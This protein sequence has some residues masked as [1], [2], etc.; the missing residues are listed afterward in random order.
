VVVPAIGVHADHLDGKY[1]LD[2][3]AGLPQPV[4]EAGI[5]IAGAVIRCD[6]LQVGCLQFLQR[7]QCGLCGA[8]KRYRV[9]EQVGQYRRITGIDDVLIKTEPAEP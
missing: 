9:P 1:R 4:A 8:M 6:G 7:R 5:G 2:Q 3:L